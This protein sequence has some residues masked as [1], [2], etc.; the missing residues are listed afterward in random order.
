M[1]GREL[2]KVSYIP[3]CLL[4]NTHPSA[5]GGCAQNNMF[6]EMINAKYLEADIFPFY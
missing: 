4:F 3:E 5:G 1:L 2:Q 6:I